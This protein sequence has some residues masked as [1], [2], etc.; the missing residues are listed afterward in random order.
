[1]SVL[2]F[3]APNKALPTSPHSLRPFL[4]GVPCQGRPEGSNQLFSFY[5]S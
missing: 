1:M 4:L 2:L 5:L 3:Y